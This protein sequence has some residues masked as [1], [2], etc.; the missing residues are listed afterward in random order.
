MESNSAN[1]PPTKG[2][3][4]VEAAGKT[5]ERE[6]NA[7]N[8]FKAPQAAEERETNALCPRETARNTGTRET[9]VS[10]KDAAAV[11]RDGGPL[12][13]AEQQLGKE[14]SVVSNPPNQ[15]Q[16]EAAIAAVP[17]TAGPDPGDGAR[18][19]GC[20]PNITDISRAGTPA[21][22]AS[23]GGS[24]SR[25]RCLRR[26]LTQM[27]KEGS[28]CFNPDKVRRII[29]AARA[30][31]E[32]SLTA[33]C[34]LD[35]D[36]SLFMHAFPDADD[37]ELRAHCLSTLLE[38]EESMRAWEEAKDS[39]ELDSDGSSSED[40]DELTGVELLR[41][42]D[43]PAP[44]PPGDMAPTGRS[45]HLEWPK[46]V[47]QQTNLV[48][49][50]AAEIEL[51]INQADWDADCYEGCRKLLLRETQQIGTVSD[52][53]GPEEIPV[54]VKLEVQHWVDEALENAARATERILSQVASMG[55]HH[56]NLDREEAGD[57]DL[58]D[59][60][61]A[62]AVMRTVTAYP[63]S[64][65][66]L[67][68][69]VRL[70]LGKRVLD[71]SATPR[72]RDLP[73]ATTS[74]VRPVGGLQAGLEVMSDDGGESC[75][76]DCTDPEGPPLASRVVQ[77]TSPRSAEAAALKPSEAPT[78]QQ[79]GGS[80]SGGTATTTPSRKKK[81]R[82]ARRA[83]R[84]AL[85]IGD[86]APAA[87]D[88]RVPLYERP[89]Q[90]P[91]FGCTR[92]HDPGD[93]PTF[94]DMTPKERLDMVH[95][96]QLC[97]LCLQH[98][99]SVGC[100]AAGKG[101]CCP[102]EGCDRPHHA[103]LHGVLKAG[104]SSPPEG[105][106]D[107]PGEPAVSVD[108]GN[109]EAARQLR[110][111]LEGLGIDPNALEVRIGVR[112]PGEPG[113]TRGDGT[114]GPG[115]TEGY[116]GR[117]READRQAHGSPDLTLSSRGEVCGLCG[118]RRS[119]DDRNGGSGKDPGE[120]C[121]QGS[122]QI[123]GQEHGVHARREQRLD[124][125]PRARQARE[126][127][128]Y[129]DDRQTAPSSGEQRV[130]PRGPGE[131]GGVWRTPARG[132]ADT[133]RRPVHQHRDRQRLCVLCHKPEYGGEVCGAPQQAPSACHGCGRRNTAPWPSPRRKLWVER[134]L[135]TP[136]WWTCW[137]S[138]TRRPKATCRGGRCSW[139]KRTRDICDGCELRSRA[140]AHSTNCLSRR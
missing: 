26:Q 116:R 95:A 49:S 108:C 40:E 13:I 47:L 87:D 82:A 77:P 94:L 115:A 136:S 48:S 137:K 63:L 61:A 90:C 80:R 33:I 39:G 12:T 81:S 38:Y 15:T 127:R 52:D 1:V 88:D 44:C 114:T 97:L 7:P 37:R 96:K 118:R 121:S 29:Q 111:L 132:A 58:T 112:Q 134:L 129:R 16:K 9:N 67:E 34:M 54:L 59:S 32:G 27:L 60:K 130:R 45:G 126:R 117:C 4:D 107:P 25:R 133:G 86:G 101:F 125:A 79:P 17:Q 22:Q 51:N 8:L 21:S 24:A 135:S 53:R 69:I 119:T 89:R 74:A 91:V 138:S 99:L 3:T 11:R 55:V 5:G 131:P 104:E 71:A 43:P 57:F 92:E 14:V 113:R 123:S 65:A 84:A 50:I 62:Q 20:R 140:T 128:R 139:A 124:E 36:I 70:A 85:E 106:A 73:Q 46:K 100:E 75:G 120:E 76:T 56:S 30:G 93:C 31:P 23:R 102:A 109:P 35:D 66:Q 19:G 41:D 68:R 28:E 98:P 64:D 10:E 105:K 83:A 103:T 122:E 6:T 18:T 42:L 78:A 2:S 72:G 110:G